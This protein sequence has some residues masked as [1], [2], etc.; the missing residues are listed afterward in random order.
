MEFNDAAISRV[1]SQMKCK[2]SM[3]ITRHK[4][5]GGPIFH[6]YIKLD[7]ALQ[8]RIHKNIFGLVHRK[9]ASYIAISEIKNMCNANSLAIKSL[10]VRARN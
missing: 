5:L 9:I 3:Y 6:L 8:K 2:N 10:T 7:A 4:R 1:L